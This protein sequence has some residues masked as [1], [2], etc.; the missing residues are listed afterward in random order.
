MRLKHLLIVIFVLVSAIPM[1]LGLQY[2]NR[3]SGQYNRE[4]FAT[5]LSS[6]SLIAKKRVLGAVERIKDNTA[7]I[8][9]RTQMRIS[10]SHWNSTRDAVHIAKISHIIQDAK[11]G[12]S[13]LKDISIFDREGRRAASTAKRPGV[14]Q[15]DPEQ[16][17]RPRIDLMAEGSGVV[18]VSV[19]P[20]IYDHTTVGFIR[21]TFYADFITDLVK[22]RTGLGE[23]GEW[24]FAVRHDSGDA[25]FAVPLKYDH[26]AAF[27]RRVA[28]VR[29]D[30][31]IV[32]ALLGNE[33]VMSHA[34][35]YLEQPVMASTRYLPELDWGL[36]AK[37]NEAEINSLVSQ[38]ENLI[39]AANFAVILLAIVAGIVLSFSVAKPLE[40][41][42]DHTAKV[43]DGSLA[44]PPKI[45]GWREVKELTRHFSYMIGALRDLNTDLQSRVEERTKE[46]NDANQRLEQLVTE[47]HLTG[48]HN[49][50]H[51]D[52]RFDEEFQRARRYKHELALVML[53]IDHF[54]SVNDT[55]GHDTGDEVLKGIAAFLKGTVRGSD[56]AARLGGEEFCLLL[57]ECSPNASMAFLDRI[58]VEVSELDFNAGSKKFNVTCSL[59]IAYLDE[60]TGDPATLLKNADEALYQAKESGRNKAIQYN[61][62]EKITALSAPAQRSSAQ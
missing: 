35:D 5:H 18:A 50:R 40:K 51:F 52:K 20:L 19:A 21:I 58:R 17:S 61:A 2:L 7:L 45:R 47:D 32:Q 26:K 6:L 10:L 38:N 29:T 36:V 54:K 60:R 41:L 14:D 1:F 22:D 53:D 46:L 31:P 59:G 3:Q 25:L 57:P 15:L 55:Y 4:Q 27:K 11:N 12:L 62:D 16:V 48:L 33:L 56:V 34:P 24:L 39:L 23:T 13:H 44:E 37:V 8:A 30:V 9:S 28:Q 49:R 43:A 42:K